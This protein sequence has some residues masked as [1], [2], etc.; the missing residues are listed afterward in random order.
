MNSTTNASFH[1]TTPN[2]SRVGA[3]FRLPVRALAGVCV[4]GALAAGV[5][6]ADREVAWLMAGDAQFERQLNALA[7]RGLRLAAISDGLAAPVA[8][9]QAPDGDA[10]PAQYRV[11]TDRDLPAALPSLLDEGF[12]PV[13]AARR[14]H[15]RT[16]V[17]F[18]KAG[19]SRPRAIW[20]FVEFAD[21]DALEAALADTSAEGYRPRLLVHAPLESWPGLSHRGLLLASKG[22]ANGARES[23]V[24]IGRSREVGEAAK[25]VEAA[26]AAGFGVDLLFTSARGGSQ[27][28]RR[29]RLVIVLSRAR[30]ATTPAAP[31]KLERTSSFGIFGSGA[32]LGAARHWADDYVFAWTPETRRQVWA[33]PIRLSDSESKGFGLEFKLRADGP[34]EQAWDIIGLVGR[35]QPTDHYELVVLTD[36]YIGPKPGR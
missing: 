19:P 10:A 8:V 12:V 30:G 33:S 3:R 26:A 35:P 27:E 9:M 24:V 7:A 28:G 20:E 14:T 36:Q 34:D 6:T 25:A 31:V 17:V 5:G 2:T 4:A 22:P 18:E 32:L 16:Q 11:V 1:R 23:R 21:L 13:G 15:T 29:E